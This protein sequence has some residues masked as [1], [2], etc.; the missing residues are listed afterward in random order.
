MKKGFYA[1]MAFSNIRKNYR[2]FIP[3]ILTGAGLLGSFYIILTLAM[4]GRLHEIKGGDYI[5]TF[6]VMG[7]AIIGLLSIILLFYTNS[8]L[9]KQREREFGLYSVL[10]MEKRH[11]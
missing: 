11:I 3:H 4:D 5:P 2:F 8:F 7:V 6:M 9:M 1:K 10:G